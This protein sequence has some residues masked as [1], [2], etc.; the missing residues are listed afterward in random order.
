M[1]VIKVI[2]AVILSFFLLCA[3]GALMGIIACNNAISSPSITK[4]IQGTNF[5]DQLYQNV[6][7][8][9][10]DKDYEIKIS[11]FLNEA[12]Q[13]DAASEFVGEYVASSIQSALQGESFSQFTKEDL[14]QLASDSLDELSAESGLTITDAQ[15]KQIENYVEQNGDQLVQE[16]NSSLPASSNPMAVS[17]GSE[18][19]QMQTVLGQSMQLVIAAICLILGLMLIMLFWSSK[20]GFIW[21]AVISL[22]VSGAYFV[23]A[24]ASNTLLF[25]FARQVGR[26]DAVAELLSNMIRQGFVFSAIAALLLTVLLVILCVLCRWI[27]NRRAQN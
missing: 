20:L 1:K 18:L 27:S 24:A 9:T 4:A 10:A 23:A 15:R 11:E 19:A 8:A 6:Q 17:S 21:W 7:D 22:L 14:Q 2:I 5:T 13:T 25:D 3:Q 26:S 16:L 12:M